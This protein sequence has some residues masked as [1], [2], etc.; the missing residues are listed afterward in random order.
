MWGEEC[1]EGRDQ[2][3]FVGQG[4]A[5]WRCVCD[6]LAINYSKALRTPSCYFLGLSS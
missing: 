3:G 4:E 2:N 6:V 5:D 1:V